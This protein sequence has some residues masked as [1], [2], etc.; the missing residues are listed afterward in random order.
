MLTIGIDFGT[1]NCSVALWR[2]GKVEL[3]PL[4][5]GNPVLP[6][7]LC[8]TREG[9][10]LV[11]RAAIRRYLELMR[12]R[13]LRYHFTDLRA[14]TSVYQHDIEA[15]ETFQRPGWEH[16]AENLDENDAPRASFAVDKTACGPV[17]FRHDGLWHYYATEELIALVLGET[18]RAE[19]YLG[20]R[21]R[22][23]DAGR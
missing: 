8:I 5:E 7:L 15:A 21:M 10:V 6:S 11:G 4:E 19:D 20:E 16:L 12:G 13:P 3:I 14:L 2:G 22:A 18:R 9:E 23:A 1:T 17:A